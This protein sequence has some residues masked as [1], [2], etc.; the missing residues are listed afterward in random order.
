MRLLGLGVAGRRFLGH[1]VLHL[2]ELLFDFGDFI[3]FEVGRQGAAPFGERLFP[4]G[5]G[6]L[7]A[8]LLGKNITEMFANGGVVRFVFDGLAQHGFGF[9]ELVL[10]VVDPAEAVKVGTVIRVKIHGALN[11]VFGLV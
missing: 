9:V 10:L 4:F 6:L 3:A 1:A 5:R 11:Q 7:A 2:V 8:A